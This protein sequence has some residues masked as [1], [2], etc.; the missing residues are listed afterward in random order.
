MPMNPCPKIPPSYNMRY[1]F[2]DGAQSDLFS[3]GNHTTSIAASAP[4][5]AISAIGQPPRPSHK[6]CNRKRRRQL[7]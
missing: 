5:S 6:T 2:R 7:Y 3:F 1:G 4:S